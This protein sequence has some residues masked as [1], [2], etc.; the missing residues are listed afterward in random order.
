[1]LS[2]GSPILQ[3]AAYRPADGGL[4]ADADGCWEGEH[5]HYLP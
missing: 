3:K 5:R 1:M 4:N 2:G